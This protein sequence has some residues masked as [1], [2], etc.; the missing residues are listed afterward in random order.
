MSKEYEKQKVL[1]DNLFHAPMHKKIF[2]KLKQTLVGT[3]IAGLFTGLV[4][5]NMFVSH[6]DNTQPLNNIVL[7]SG[8]PGEHLTADIQAL[9]F[10]QFFIQDLFTMDKASFQFEKKGIA[11][12][13]SNSD[14]Y[15][16][17]IGALND[18]GYTDKLNSGHYVYSH[19]LQQASLESVKNTDGK[20]YYQV[21]VPYT[22]TWD[23]KQHSNNVAHLLLIK[24][25]NSSQFNIDHIIIE[26]VKS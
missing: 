12:L 19:S 3:F 7:T 13:F 21:A 26:P 22:Q 20:T 10:S 14:K 11:D 8:T 6:H 4:L 9:N 17:F 16:N 24:D 18:S 25:N 15:N 5:S 23:G 2:P 1:L